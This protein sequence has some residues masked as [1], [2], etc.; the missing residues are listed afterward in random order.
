MLVDEL[1]EIV[2]PDHVLADADRRARYET[3]WTGRFR[4][5]TPAVVRPA[6]TED[7][8]AVIEV[9]RRHRASLV[10][11]GG[12][13][14][15]VGGSVPLSGEIV[16][17]TTRL[18]AITD[19][20]ADTGQL[21]AGAGAT[22]AAVQA[23]AASI[24]WRYGVDFAARDSATVGGMV[25]TNA[26][27]VR[28]VRHGSTR[29]QLLGVE[30]VMGT[31]A[32]INRLGGLVK[33]NTGY[34]LAGLLCGS[35]GTL[36]IVCRARLALVAP[37]DGSVTAL[38]G[39]D[40]VS[41]AVSATGRLR[42]EVP[43]LEAVEMVLRRGAALVAS[44][45]GIDPVLD[46]IPP[47]QLVVEAV[48]PPDPLETLAGVIG[49]LSTATDVAVATDAARAAALWHVREAHTGSI[50][51]LGTPLKYDVT[52]PAAGLAAFCTTIGERVLAVSPGSTTWIFGHVADGNVHVNVTG[53]E[54]ARA[55]AVDDTVLS[56]V[57]S[58]NGSVSA[59]H[60]IG[61]AKRRW[62]VTNRGAGDV[63]TMAA[64]AGALDPDSICNPNV[65]MPR[66]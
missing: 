17:S 26:G 28:V 4:G 61:T 42:R 32:V 13:T 12:N 64:I 39:F 33:D 62:L 18:D 54:P 35:E 11:Q 59:E 8:R 20:D 5:S 14:G 50:A 37:T 47:V 46:P 49:S 29:R 7:V 48:G 40:D 36:G 45:T 52:I 63:A 21:T 24:G 27:G 31:G 10:P 9:C 2:G 53:E 1:C 57:Q 16:V 51:R 66:G 58:A 15:L 3:D 41:A 60:G 44:E 56:A 38:V 25:A 22:L 65:L 43:G 6:S 19:L 55:G 34:D 30:A 23:A